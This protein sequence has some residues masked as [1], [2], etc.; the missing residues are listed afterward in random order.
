MKYQGVL[1]DTFFEC[2][3]DSEEEAEKIM[4]QEAI[5]QLQSGENGIIVWDIQPQDAQNSQ[6]GRE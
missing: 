6:R 4:I 5:R 2:E 3:A 1:P